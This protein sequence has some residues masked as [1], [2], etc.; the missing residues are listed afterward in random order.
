MRLLR[1]HA[2]HV[3]L[4]RGTVRR[5]EGEVRLTTKERELL[6]YLVARPSVDLSREEL[7]SEVWGYAPTVRTRALDTVVK[8]LRRKLEI[9]RKK[10]DH[11]L[12]VWGH[13][14]RF[15][16]VPAG[17][18][19]PEGLIGRDEELA[20]LRAA[21]VRPGALVV[22][23][24]PGGVGKSR[25]VT[26]ALASYDPVFVALDAVDAELLDDAVGR[27]LP[28]S[29]LPVGVRLSRLQR[30][31]I[32]DDAEHLVDPL[33]AAITRWRADA[34]QVVVVVTSRV[35]L[36]HADALRIPLAP[37]GV[38][39]VVRMLERLV[40]A[41]APDPAWLQELAARLDG[42]PLAAELVAP[43]S[44]VLGPEA[45]LERVEE[46]LDREGAS[47][48]AV[49]ARSFEL[50]EPP[51]REALRCVGC[52]PEDLDAAD[53]E[54]LTGHARALEHLVSLRQ[55]SLLHGADDGRLRLLPL[56]RRT[57]RQLLPAD[58][59]LRARWAEHVLARSRQERSLRWVSALEQA[60]RDEELSD[61]LRGAVGVELFSALPRGRGAF[62]D[63]AFAEDVYA[64]MKDNP[65]PDARA[66]GA[67]I[68]CAVA[69]RGDLRPVDAWFAEGV[70]WASAAAP[71]RRVR[72]L[73]LWATFARLH[74][75]TDEALAHLEVAAALQADLPADHHGVIM[76]TELGL[77]HRIE[78]RLDQALAALELAQQCAERGGTPWS[79]L[80]AF[81]RRGGTLLLAGHYASARLWLERA[82]DLA[83]RHGMPAMAGVIEQSLAIANQEIGDLEAASTYHLADPEHQEAFYRVSH[84]AFRALLHLE[85][86]DFAKACGDAA[87]ARALLTKAHGPLVGFVDL[88]EGLCLLFIDDPSHLHLLRRAAEAPHTQVYRVAAVWLAAMDQGDVPDVPPGDRELAQLVATLCDGVRG[89]GVQARLLRSWLDRRAL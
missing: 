73:S 60:F 77:L 49:V 10:P 53:V 41:E 43:W 3:D 35:A 50:L 21:V 36:E 18:T 71:W 14:Y 62:I 2:G 33:V 55:A 39:D 23:S 78:G 47:M 5:S 67:F 72:A 4:V 1:I 86:G 85:L 87:A 69:L 28:A 66:D 74:R 45:L 20:A 65:D 68:R 30:P 22:V 25:L 24:G 19:V 83:H 59:P 82:K 17:A 81:H 56:V 64:L 29:D 76:Y 15:E 34:P 32:L 7:L 9:D 75:R 70:E 46:L 27:A 63:G 89:A 84:L 79:R 37:L 51:V 12:T 38:D 11:L 40:E 8:E 54:V 57:V 44:S 80:L 58:I 26:D 13:G 52:F 31:L 16:P 6:T 61:A 88:V 42:L 48:Q